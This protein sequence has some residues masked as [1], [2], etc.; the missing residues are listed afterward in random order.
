MRSVILLSAGLVLLA[1]TSHRAEEKPPKEAPKVAAKLPK[2][3]HVKVRV[4]VEIRG[5]LA[6]TGKGVTVAAQDRVYNLLH[7]NEENA[8]HSAPTTYTLD[9]SR[10][11]DLRELAKVLDGKEVVVSGVAE[12]R[13]Y[14]HAPK[15]GPGG[16]TGFSGPHPSPFAFPVPAWYLQTTVLV[17]SLKSAGSE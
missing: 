3:G 15:R 14:V 16:G 10:A 5:T 1:A 6:V 17:A 11:K 9:F 12:V 8:D 4:E 2:S 7:P 13:R